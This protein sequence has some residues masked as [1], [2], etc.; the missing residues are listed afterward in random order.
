[1]FPPIS[2]SSLTPLPN[3]EI[4]RRGLEINGLGNRGRHGNADLLHRQYHVS[5]ERES[6]FQVRVKRADE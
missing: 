4:R 1:M 3:L 6:G 5:R 2:L